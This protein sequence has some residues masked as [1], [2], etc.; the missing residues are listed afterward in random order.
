[1]TSDSYSPPPDNPDA[2]TSQKPPVWQNIQ[3]PAE[4]TVVNAQPKPRRIQRFAAV[5][6][7][8]F[9]ACGGLFVAFG[10]GMVFERSVVA[11]EASAEATGV[12]ETFDRAWN[13]VLDNYVDESVIDQDLMLEGAIEGMLDTLGDQG[14]TRYLTAEETERDR[15]SSSG[16]YKG[17]G[18]L[19]EEQDGRI[20][21]VYPFENSPAREAGVLA[22]DIIVAVDGVDVSEMQLNEIIDLIRGPVD[23]Q[24]EVTF[25]RP[26]D[27]ELHTF[28]LTRAEIEISSVS[29]TMLE[30]DIA[31]ISL[32][33]F[34]SGSGD[35]LQAALKEAQDAGAAGV[36][37]DLRNNPG[38]FVSEAMQVAS[39][40]L[41]DDTVVYISQTRDGG[42]EEHK[43]TSQSINIGDTPFV[44][45]INEGS[46]SASEIV[47]GAILASGE[48]TVIGESTVGT[49]TVLNQFELG[50]GSTIW[51]GVELWLTPDGEL[52]RHHG[53]TPE[54]VV[55]LAEGQ[56]PF[57]PPVGEATVPADEELNDDQ[58]EYGIDLL[59]NGHT[60]EETLAAD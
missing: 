43:T 36:I 26:P 55:P 22:G 28:D 14:H 37:F 58:L 60:A 54:I 9:L 2:A 31:L 39:T 11:D 8:S 34:T 44:V 40:F 27:G 32:N 56:F 49:G 29:W 42:K 35:D 51:L 30:D 12:P 23:T 24:V 6:I 4:H 53:I 3:Q 20:V 38:G 13:V 41:P 46:A 15:E 52:I 5:L 16:T 7:I 59:L 45:L 33:Q 19:V 25:E 17:V 10:A 57:E 48:A 21:V 18:I 1:M 50:D 47:S